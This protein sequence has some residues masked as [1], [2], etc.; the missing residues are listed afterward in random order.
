MKTIQL[1]LIFFIT[2]VFIGCD[3][4]LPIIDESR[5]NL[6][7]ITLSN[8]PFFF[9]DSLSLGS[10]IKSQIPVVWTNG[11]I[12]ESYF[13]VIKINELNYKFI[14]RNKSDKGACTDDIRGGFAPMRFK[15]SQIGTYSIFIIDRQDTFSKTLVVY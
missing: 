12:Y 11:C 13:E 7:L 10:E 3:P 8:P 5:V 15:P 2:I 4:E 1:I 9:S 6:G 14:L